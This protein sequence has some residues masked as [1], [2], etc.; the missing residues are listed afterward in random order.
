MWE[1]VAD[2]AGFW[3]GFNCGIWACVAL[4]VITEFFRPK[5]PKGN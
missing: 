1:F 2:W 4:I 5:K 3:L